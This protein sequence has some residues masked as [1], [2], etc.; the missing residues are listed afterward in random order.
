MRSPPALLCALAFAFALAACSS[1]EP[2]TM[3]TTPPPPPTSGRTTGTTGAT[4]SPTSSPEP[5]VRLPGGMAAVVDDP[6]DVAAI[7][8]GDLTSLVPA[9]STPGPSAVLVEP[10][11]PIDQVA[12]AW[13]AG[14]ALA[15]RTGLI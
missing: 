3:P 10:D 5:D 8:G 11:A 12:V 4:G 6:A 13:R 15:G 2:S 14:D 9:G 1:D 7:S